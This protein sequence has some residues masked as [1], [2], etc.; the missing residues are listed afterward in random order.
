MLKMNIKQLTAKFDQLLHRQ[1]AADEQLIGMRSELESLQV[2]HQALQVAHQALQ[3]QYA[4]AQ[5][6]EQ[7]LRCDY[8]SLLASTQSLVDDR[9]R[10]QSRVAELEA[11]NNKLTN[12]LWGRRSERRETE[13]QLQLWDLDEPKLTEQEQAVITAAAEAQRLS[14]EE[15]L[16]RLEAR[17]KQRKQ[18]PRSEELPAHFPRRERIFDLNDTEKEGLKYIGDAVT[19][20]L[21]FEKPQMYVDRIVRRK[22][23]KPEDKSAGVIAAA[24]P[25]A[26]VEGGKYDVSIHAAVVSFK[27]G[28]HLPTYREQE[29]FSMLGWYP[30]RSTLN[31]LMNQSCE[32]IVPLYDQ[33]RTLL[34]RDSIVL[35]DDTQ[36]R[37][38][39]RGALSEVDEAL[40]GKRR[41][42]ARGKPGSLNQPHN[43]GPPGKSA[44]AGSVTSYVWCYRG[45]DD[46]YPYNIFDWTLTREHATVGRH[47]LNFQG[48]LVG[49]AFGGN[50]R[51]AASSAGRIDFAA[52][53]VHARREFVHSEKD[54]PQLS[55]QALSFYRQLYEIEER[56]RSMSAAD[57]LVLRQR[58]SVLVW[59]RMELWLDQ[60]PS[61][62]ILPKSPFG[63]AVGYLRNQWSGLQRYLSNGRLPI[64]N[65][66]TERTIRPWT[67]GRKNWMFL[68]H[69]EA[70]VSRL[71]LYSIVSSAAR[72]QLVLTDY[73]EDVLT[74]LSIARSTSPQDLEAGSD[75]LLGLLPDRWAASHPQSVCAG[76]QQENRERSET[77]RA[78]RARRRLASTV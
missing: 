51:I 57:R 25:P 66:A 41:T 53:N 5:V 24:I 69:P 30:E 56:G 17:R 37:L 28:F 78:K 9:A 21:C 29:L 38:L 14:D 46:A 20:R 75:M 12:M 8:E 62:R 3:Q 54:E 76:R 26:V 32:L 16:R 43:T 50:A 13:G 4:D 40:L 74:Q 55:S 60:L 39:T 67:I 1:H 59:R 36:V 58:E 42:K 15:L 18:T 72:H 45:L 70:A 7:Q 61:S 23:V 34:M 6:A 71:Q 10:L 31:E 44:A 11:A 73:L 77:T 27:Y 35:G 49:D 52:C 65:S 33:M 64:D 47:L 48:T 19:E 22:Y 68:G 63:K 2:A